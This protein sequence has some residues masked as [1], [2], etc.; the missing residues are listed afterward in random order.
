[1]A[2]IAINDVI[3]RNQYEATGGETDLDYTFPIFDADHL[4]VQ[5]T[6][7]LDPNN[8]V[9]LVRGVDYDVTG[10]NDETG[11]TIVFK[12]GP[13][14]TGAIEDFI[15]TLTRQLPYERLNDYQF[16][17]DFESSDVN[18]DFDSLLMMIQQLN[19]DLKASVRLQG[20][21]TLTELPIRIQAAADR[22]NRVFGFN[23]TGTEIIAGPLF[24][25]IETVGGAINEII[26]VSNNIA[27]VIT[28][29]GNTTNI[30]AVAANSANINTVAGNTANINTVAGISGNITTVAGIAGN[31]TTVAG[32][33]AAVS[34]VAGIS[35][36]VSTVA[37]NAAAV[38]TVATN[39]ADVNT[40]AANIGAIIAAPGAAVSA[41]NARDAAWAWSSQ[42]EDVGVND[43]I[44]P[45][46]F[47]AYHWSR[48][49][50][51]A[52]SGTGAGL[53]VFGVAA[54]A[55]GIRGDIVAAND[56]EVLRR[57]GTALGFGTIATAGI[58]N[59]AVTNAKQANMAANTVK[60]NSTAGAAAPG[61]LAMA[62]STVLARLATGNIV[63]AT[64]T[65]ILDLITGTAA[66]GDTLYRGASAW[67]RL[68]KGTALQ[69]MRMNAGATA[70]EWADMN[71]AGQAK[72]WVNFNGTGTV[73]IRSSYNVSS[74]TDIG[75]GSYKANFTTAMP[76]ANY[77]LS[78]CSMRAGTSTGSSSSNN[79][80]TFY[81]EANGVNIGTWAQTSGV[82][83]DHEYIQL[84]VFG[85]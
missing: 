25:D 63:A 69:V 73:A 14:P 70:P 60:A 26:T 27:S 44:N 74:I 59:S 71:G 54:N 81:A 20:T 52:A 1:M 65:Q 15:Y 36:A 2:D 6:D 57:S 46:G 45:A 53:S 39:I 30:N 21:D 43:G 78:L 24:T 31:V 38:S 7:P 56:G 50:M 29:A 75:T 80:P 35:A 10:V 48:K 67:S 79:T 68:A 82:F 13:Y 40:A 37:T 66:Q 17:G 84:L 42:A 49:A 61:D 23:A 9:T 19:R 22:A 64:I 62:A 77:A 11:G 83:A 41:A 55:T 51:A 16:S 12:I 5:E 85:N 72:A 47:S 8:P 3:P 34:T 18:V 4:L 76:N 32:I 28:V 58:A 33:S